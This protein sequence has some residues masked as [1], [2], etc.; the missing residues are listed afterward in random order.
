MPAQQG[1]QRL[2]NVGNGT[3]ARGQQHHPDNGKDTCTLTIAMM[4]L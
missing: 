2:C 3:S 4:P 1:Q